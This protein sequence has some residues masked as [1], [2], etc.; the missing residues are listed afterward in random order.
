MTQKSRRALKR[1][2]Y[3]SLSMAQR[4]RLGASTVLGNGM[5]YMINLPQQ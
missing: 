4:F 2:S 3:R 1:E 5:D